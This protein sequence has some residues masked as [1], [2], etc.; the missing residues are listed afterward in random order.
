MRSLTDLLLQ[1]KVVKQDK[2]INELIFLKKSLETDLR[3]Y[4]NWEAIAQ[5]NL[6]ISLR[7]GVCVIEARGC[8]LHPYLYV[9]EILC[10]GSAASEKWQLPSFLTGSTPGKSG[11][12]G[13]TSGAHLHTHG[14]SLVLWRFCSR[15]AWSIMRTGSCLALPNGANCIWSRTWEKSCP[16][17]LLRTVEIS[18]RQPR[19]ANISVLLVKA[20][21]TALPEI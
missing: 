2:C 13:R 10:M 6:C 1:E 7:K 11:Q 15:W 3:T 8:S 5:E 9:I 14:S 12:V 16:G 18:K 20:N 21:K 4:H 19:K 17:T